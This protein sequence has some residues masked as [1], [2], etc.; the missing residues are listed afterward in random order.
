M[1]TKRPGGRP[2]G[3]AA[4]VATLLAAVA[5]A[6]VWALASAPAFAAPPASGPAVQGDPPACQDADAWRAA[7]AQ[8]PDAVQQADALLALTRPACIDPTLAPA[9]RMALDAWRADLLDRPWPHGYD[10]LPAA[11]KARLHL[12]RAGVWASRAQQLA[13][14]GR[15]VRAAAERAQAELDSVRRANLGVD[16]RAELVEAV[17]LVEAARRGAERAETL[18]RASARGLRLVVHAGAQPGQTCVLLFAAE[19]PEGAAGVAAKAPERLAE[20]CTTGRVWPHSAAL[21]PASQTLSIT[22]QAPDGRAEVWLF[23]AD[24]AAAAAPRGRLVS[25]WRVDVLP[26]DA[27]VA[28]V[29]AQWQGGR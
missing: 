28:P 9:A 11:T 27:A 24:G 20:R 8:R 1:P 21:Q 2:P 3:R 22:V 18:A 19:A 16:D 13:L 5:G 15:P 29:L 6:V 23:R 10:A 4:Y 12:R 7:L 25:P 26:G 17:M 14:A